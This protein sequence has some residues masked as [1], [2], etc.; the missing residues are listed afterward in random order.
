VP[1]PTAHTVA[2]MMVVPAANVT[3]AGTLATAGLSELRLIVNPAAGAGADRVTNTFCRARALMLILPG[4]KLIE[5][6]TCT[7]W[8]A[9]GRP[10][11]DAVMAADPKS[12]PVTWGGDAV[13]V[14]PAGISTLAGFTVIFEGSLLVNV[15]IM[16]DGGAGADKVTGKSTVCPTPTVRLDGNTMPLTPAFVS[17]KLAGSATPATD[18]LTT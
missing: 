18:A 1:G 12:N 8:L 15:I 17:E 6:V 5:S 11:V 7:V 2:L 14:A 3:V 13:V 4:E 9:D 10:M 16:P